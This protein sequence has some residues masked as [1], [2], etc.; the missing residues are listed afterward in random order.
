MKQ[1]NGGPTLDGSAT[2]RSIFELPFIAPYSS[3]VIASSNHLSMMEIKDT[4]S[5]AD[6][7]YGT[8]VVVVVVHTNY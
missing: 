4:T 1:K 2:K 7:M 8:V 6:K 3:Y 5:P